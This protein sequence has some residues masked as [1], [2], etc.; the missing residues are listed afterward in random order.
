MTIRPITAGEDAEIATISR[1]MMR[2][3]AAYC[4][5]AGLHE[6]E[7]EQVCAAVATGCE[8]AA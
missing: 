8:M 3:I 4:E 6:V 1:R 7:A 2:E 5:G